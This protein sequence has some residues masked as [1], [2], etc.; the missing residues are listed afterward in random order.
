MLHLV[1]R[2]SEKLNFVEINQS[3][4]FDCLSL[5]LLFK[6]RKS[7]WLLSGSLIYCIITAYSS[8]ST[9]QI[10]RLLQNVTYRK[11]AW[12]ARRSAS[13]R[14]LQLL[15]RGIHSWCSFSCCVTSRRLQFRLPPGS[16]SDKL[17]VFPDSIMIFRIFV[18]FLLWL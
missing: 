11:A 3:L 4:T 12:S 18:S 1:I 15:A 7:F 16:E 9:Q 17:V 6:Y 5:V 2:N 13:L 10:H 8:P 14:P